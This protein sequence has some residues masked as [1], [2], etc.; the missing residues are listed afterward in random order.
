MPIADVVFT[1]GAV[2]SAGA[3]ASVAADVAVL[4]GR[5]VAVGSTDDLRAWVGDAT[6]V[7][8]TSGRLVVA[9]FQDAHVHPIGAGVEML[10][11]DL[12][13][14][15]DAADCLRIIAEYAQANPDEPWIRGAGWSME[16]FP[17]G[18]PMAADLDAVVADRPV[19]LSNRD[20]HGAW[21]NSLALAL[22]GVTAETPDPSDGRI[23]RDAGGAPSG[24]LHEGA[25]A[26]VE[27]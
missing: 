7:V 1:G 26:L 10:Q 21:A 4:D 9:G 24:T 13:G 18:T 2:F 5:I 19:L 14:A 3:A 27:T 6:T 20:H 12:T 25:V 22:A 17:G 16:F 11:C 8:D 23:E 15:T